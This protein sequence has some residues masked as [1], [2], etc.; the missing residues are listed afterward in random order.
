MTLADKTFILAS[1]ETASPS[2]DPRWA[3]RICINADTLKTSKLV[4][5]DLVAISGSE[6]SDVEVRSCP[7]TLVHD[8]MTIKKLF[9]VGLLWPS[10]DIEDHGVY[11]F[12]HNSRH[13]LEL[14][15]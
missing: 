2:E 1:S 8:L 10:L 4:A 13:T 6:Q 15:P 3:R 12:A 7:R 14:Y 5:G 9:A 11:N